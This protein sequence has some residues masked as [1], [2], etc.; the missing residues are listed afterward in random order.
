MAAAMLAGILLFFG[1]GLGAVGAARVVLG[2]DDV[3]RSASAGDPSRRATAEGRARIG[4]T[5]KGSTASDSPWRTATIVFAL[6]GPLAVVGVGTVGQLRRVASGASADLESESRTLFVVRHIEALAFACLGTKACTHP[7]GGPLCPRCLPSVPEPQPSLGA[8]PVMVVQALRGRPHLLFHPEIEAILARAATMVSAVGVSEEALARF[9]FAHELAHIRHRDTRVATFL[10]VWLR[11]WWLLLLGPATGLALSVLLGR[12]G[13][14][15]FAGLEL[16]CFVTAY[17]CARYF[18][19]QR[20]LA[21]DGFAASRTGS[22]ALLSNLDSVLFAVSMATSLQRFEAT[23]Q[24]GL[25]FISLR[26]T[27]KRWAAQS[28][29]T[30]I[31][32]RVFATHPDDAARRSGAVAIS[33]VRT[34]PLEPSFA[35]CCGWGLASGVVLQAAALLAWAL[36]GEPTGG[37]VLGEPRAAATLGVA[38]AGLVLSTFVAVLAPCQVVLVMRQQAL[39]RGA[40]RVAASAG[41]IAIITAGLLLFPTG[42]P[43]GFRFVSL[44]VPGTLLLTPVVALLV[45]ALRHDVTTPTIYDMYSYQSRSGSLRAWA[46]ALLGLGA[47]FGIM[48]LAPLLSQ[49]ILQKDRPATQ[50]MVILGTSVLGGIAGTIPVFNEATFRFAG[51]NKATG[52]LLFFLCLSLGSVGSVFVVNLLLPEDIDLRLLLIGV[53]LG[54]V[55]LGAWILAILAR[56]GTGWWT[57]AAVLALEASGRDPAVLGQ[58]AVRRDLAWMLHGYQRVNAPMPLVVGLEHTIGAL[59]GGGSG[60]GPATAARLRA[61]ECATGGFAE[62]EGARPSL[63][64]TCLGVRALRTLGELESDRASVHADWL[65]AMLFESTGS[66][67]PM[68]FAELSLGLEALSSCNEVLG[69]TAGALPRALPVNP[70]WSTLTRLWSNEFAIDDEV[71]GLAAIGLWARLPPPALQELPSPVVDWMVSR[72]LEVMDGRLE[73]EPYRT[74]CYAVAQRAFAPSMPIADDIEGRLAA[75]VSAFAP[76]RA[77]SRSG[78][79][80][81]A[82]GGSSRGL[83]LEQGSGAPSLGSSSVGDRLTTLI[84]LDDAR[85]NPP[86]LEQ[87]EASAADQPGESNGQVPRSSLLRLANVL[88]F[89]VELIATCVTLAT[90]SV[91][92]GAWSAGLILGTRFIAGNIGVF[93][94]VVATAVIGVDIERNRFADHLV[95]AFGLLTDLVVFLV[96]WQLVIRT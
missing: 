11:W 56:R 65:L 38:W 20:E 51:R 92:L 78:W 41:V 25:G 88:V 7:E 48:L 83:D 54:V 30:T 28:R 33:V 90:Q 74:Y 10:V 71:R 55:L 16:L 12:A 68:R 85:F 60:P 27:T 23:R 13:L 35:A 73:L 47:F 19:R 93:A 80:A 94:A 87:P 77:A 45:L 14:F 18:L 17:L 46:T 22:A 59:Q 62:K 89:L 39:I 52:Y 75:A 86:S 64:G 21:A 67:R 24:S 63:R 31:V 61:C 26:E 82:A 69:T 6:L 72:S 44:S 9:V 70:T 53:V 84:L 40:L 76:D 81:A 34:I 29:L 5:E 4:D 37:D 8:T 1:L 49:A 2:D 66:F 96:V 43:Q 57:M 91:W 79:F 15:W 95:D 42:T 3:G 36:A 32:Q 50:M 58:P